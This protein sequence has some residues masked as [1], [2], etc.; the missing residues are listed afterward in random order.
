MDESSGY[1]DEAESCGLSPWDL[2]LEISP[3][4]LSFISLFRLL[5]KKA[6]GAVGL[7]GLMAMQESSKGKAGTRE[8]NGVKA[9]ANETRTENIEI[10][11]AIGIS[12]F[13]TVAG[14]R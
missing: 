10:C 7:G 4:C 2:S 13:D 6:R 14:A 3:L 1:N 5:K 8:L 12:S 9:T 11:V